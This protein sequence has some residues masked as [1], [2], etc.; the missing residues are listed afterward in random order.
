MDSPYD[1][2]F[3]VLSYDEKILSDKLGMSYSDSTFKPEPPL[4][5][6]NRVMLKMREN[7]MIRREIR[8]EIQREREREREQPMRET[9]VGGLSQARTDVAAKDHGYPHGSEIIEG[10]S[11]CGKQSCSCKQVAKRNEEPVFENKTLMF[12]VIILAAF[13]VVQWLNQQVMTTQMN[14]IMNTM[15]KLVDGK[16]I[17]DTLADVTSTVPVESTTTT[18]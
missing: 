11:S 9:F 3:D 2:P 5:V 13:C 8:R 6:N 10:M 4:S 7:D 18:A 14:D 1:N 15:C 12:I 17:S 16:S